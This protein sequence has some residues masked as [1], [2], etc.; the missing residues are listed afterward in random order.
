M[1]VCHALTR[2]G[3]GL[4][5]RPAID[6]TGTAGVFLAGDWVGAAGRLADASFASGEAAGRAAAEHVM[7]RRAATG[8]TVGR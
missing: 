8:A 5:G 6:A 4:S 1:T 3:S 7:R 2:P